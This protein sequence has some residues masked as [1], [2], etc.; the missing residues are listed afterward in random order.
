ML[1]EGLSRGIWSPDWEFWLPAS[2]VGTKAQSAFALDSGADLPYCHACPV[3]LIASLTDSSVHVKSHSHMV[4]C[5]GWISSNNHTS[6]PDSHG[7]CKL[8]YEV[9]WHPSHHVLHHIATVM[10][11]LCCTHHVTQLLACK[12]THQRMRLSNNNAEDADNSHHNHAGSHIQMQWTRWGMPTKRPHSSC[13]SM[14]ADSLALLI[15]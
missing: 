1:A 8:V 4:S 3:T 11:A 6:L 15:A 7:S 9:A 12:I 10:C 14:C 5:S 13:S 2:R